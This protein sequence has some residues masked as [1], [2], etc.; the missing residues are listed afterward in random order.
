MRT[1][2]PEKQNVDTKKPSGGA[3]SD[4]TIQAHGA[5]S[6][7]P[8]APVRVGGAS[9][10]SGDGPGETPGDVPSQEGKA[11]RYTVQ[12]ELGRG[13][14][15]R[16][17]LVND[18]LLERE[19]ALKELVTAGGKRPGSALVE[20]FL[21]EARLSSRL[22]H[23][24]IIPV[25]DLGCHPD[26]SHYYTM[27]FIEGQGFDAALKACTTLQ[28]RLHFLPNFRDVCNALA[29]AHSRSIIHR[30]LK[31][32][33]IIIGAYGETVVVDWGLAKIL[34]EGSPGVAEA[35]AF[36]PPERERGPRKGGSPMHTRAGSILGTPAYM[37]PEQTLGRHDVID[38][39]SDQYSLGAI[40][41]EILTGRPPHLADTV[42]SML[43][44]VVSEPITPV[45]EL[46]P[47]AP[48]ELCV[49][50]QKALSKDPQDRYAS[51]K[52]MA[53]ELSAY[54]SG[55]KVASYNYT[56]RELLLRFLR[57]HRVAVGAGILVVLSLV[58][59]LVF[60]SWAYRRESV[61]RRAATLAQRKEAQ[62]RQ[63]AQD[64]ETLAVTQKRRA[65]DALEQN[66]AEQRQSH[67]NLA[68]ATL[69]RARLMSEM[70]RYQEALVLGAASRLHNP[71]HP[72]S[73]WHVADYGEA[74]PRALH[75]LSRA[76]AVVLLAHAS[77]AVSL[78]NVYRPKGTM[79]FHGMMSARHHWLELSPERRWLVFA[80][81]TSMV[82]LH[83][84]NGGKPTVL[85]GGHAAPVDLA[86][87]GAR[88][89][90]LLSVD[91]EGRAVLWRPGS[92]ARLRSLEMPARVEGFSL[93]A[94]PGTADF[95][96]TT[97][98]GAIWRIDAINGRFTEVKPAGPGEFDSVCMHPSGRQV[99]ST[100]RDGT[101][102]L[103]RL[104]DGNTRQ[105]LQ[106]K[107]GDSYHC[108]FLDAGARVHFVEYLGTASSEWA[109]DPLAGTLKP[110]YR[111]TLPW[112]PLAFSRS[113][114]TQLGW[115]AFAPTDLGLWDPVAGAT[116]EMVTGQDRQ[117]EG[118]RQADPENLL[119]VDARGRVMHWKT[120]PPLRQE[121]APHRGRVQIVQQSP[122]M[123]RLVSA[124]WD[125]TVML[126]DGAGGPGSVL[127]TD[128]N[129]TVWS[130]DWSP[131]G[132]FVA[133]I[134]SHGALR[135][136]DPSSR[137]L[138]FSHDCAGSLF[139]TVVFSPDSSHLHV[140]SGAFAYRFAMPSGELVHKVKGGLSNTNGGPTAPDRRR[141]IFREGNEIV[142]LDYQTGRR[143][144]LPVTG[145]KPAELLNCTALEGEV[146]ACQDY[147]FAI[148]VYRTQT[149]EK[150]SVLVGNTQ[151]MS[152]IRLHPNG[153][154]IL[155]SC[156][157]NSSRLWDLATG[158][159]IYS[160]ISSTEA[161]SS[162]DSQFFQIS[163]DGERIF[164]SEG[165][166]VFS[167]PLDPTL[168]A[169]APQALIQ[170][171]QD[172]SGLR[173]EGVT[174][175]PLSAD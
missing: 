169:M 109:F 111:S 144:T 75:L 172:R 79:A 74:H 68:E 87:F 171:A 28:Q 17:L 22:G 116:R 5:V 70:R 53:A 43:L 12:R 59:T 7:P 94:L 89:D 165:A 117:L 126:H 80:D 129:H 24:S 90:T 127:G 122:D 15:G 81:G 30:D 42:Q 146:F 58:A 82:T 149:L 161:R 67:Y 1:D 20:R 130:V 106:L 120:H 148:H 162:L 13:G 97:L 72:G 11:P 29:F 51:T 69:E 2:P 103:T 54:L 132:R 163:R 119:A 60:M 77:T 157:D 31:P 37:S 168:R 151:A 36:K 40:L 139:P 102:R 64:A 18:G 166:R 152:S 113:H 156:D 44:K 71:A 118:I 8:P 88:G 121:Y 73:P 155:T 108:A 135:A 92:G 56:P 173:L 85:A 167:V 19:V 21:R 33:N 99:L 150:L 140:L 143:R 137:R 52:E 105:V 134:D 115:I 153:R 46:V 141:A 174:L 62:E 98:Q 170:Q 100:Y 35:E 25:H 104:P 145:L 14:M 159:P 23:P 136:Y 147:R 65:E 175:K 61:A 39:R 16:V 48:R 26:G 38:A 93:L 128:F 91:R 63:K 164:L 32:G 83:D 6:S 76:D 107:S 10:E 142:E 55:E 9:G 95:L 160:F 96:W 49:I 41:Y 101:V 123:K 4:G 158:R 47:Q 34:G 78:Q 27:R 66:R 50:A 131:D 138:L 57:R 133:A 114:L 112:L 154:W 110:V 124:S 3:R 125:R 84:L 86:A 45:S